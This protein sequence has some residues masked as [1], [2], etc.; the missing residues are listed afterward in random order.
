MSI[1]SEAS[2]LQGKY[3][4][5]SLGEEHYG[6]AVS[7]ILEI[8]QPST[9]TFVP[10]MPHYIRGLINLRGKVVP[11][12][13]LKR[14]LGLGEHSISPQ[15]CI[16]VVQIHLQEGT[17]SNIGLLVDQVRS[18]VDMDRLQV[19]D[20]PDFGNRQDITFLQGVAKDDNAYIH[21]ID[22][23]KLFNQI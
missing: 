15:A 20:A 4:T 10:R 9:I 13:D 5:F 17:L 21:L 18:V 12:V 19:E 8:A 1:L 23:E 3:L 2:V 14:R 11:V 7:H 16:I 22:I 6:I